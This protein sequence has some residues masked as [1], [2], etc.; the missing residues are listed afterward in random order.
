[1]TWSEQQWHAGILAN[2]R[3]VTTFKAFF[4]PF[5]SFTASIRRAS[6]GRTKTC[7]RCRLGLQLTSAWNSSWC[8]S[9]PNTTYTYNNLN[10]HTIYSRNFADVN[11]ELRQ[12][13]LLRTTILHGLHIAWSSSTR[14]STICIHSVLL[15]DHCVN[16]AETD[17]VELL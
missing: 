12:G 16:F 5:I 10:E 6:R 1:M 8:W 2:Q 11:I 15:G 9:T 7:T 4:I 14:A 3:N 13:Y 17:A